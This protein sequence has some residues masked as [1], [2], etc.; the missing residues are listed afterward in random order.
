MKWKVYENTTGTRLQYQ[1]FVLHDGPPLADA[2]TPTNYMIETYLHSGRFT[3]RL[4]G[5]DSTGTSS[6]IQIGPTLAARTWHEIELIVNADAK[7][8]NVFIN[9]TQYGTNLP[10]TRS[11]QGKKIDH[12]IIGTRQSGDDN[13]IYYDDIIITP[14]SNLTLNPITDQVVEIG[15]EYTAEVPIVF[16][17][18]GAELSVVSSNS[19]A[20]SAR[21]VGSEGSRKVSLTGIAAA[22]NVRITVTVK[23]DLGNEEETSFH[24]ALIVPKMPDLPALD[25]IEQL[26]VNAVQNVKVSYTPTNATVITV[27][28]SNPEVAAVTVQSQTNGSA[29][30]QVRG[31]TAG[32]ATIT[33]TATRPGGLTVEDRFEVTVASRTAPIGLLDINFNALATGVFDIAGPAAGTPNTALPELTNV[34]NSAST[35]ATIVDA[36]NG[37]KHFTLYSPSADTKALFR[38]SP[39]SDGILVFEFRW[40][41]DAALNDASVSIVGGSGAGSAA[42]D[43]AFTII[44]SE[45]NRINYRTGGTANTNNTVISDWTAGRW[46]GVKVEMNVKAKTY[47][48]SIDGKPVAADV[49]FRYPVNTQNGEIWGVAVGKGNNRDATVRI[50]DLKVYVPVS[51]ALELN[52]N[53]LEATNTFDISSLPN[54]LLPALT[55]MLNPTGANLRVLEKT[56]NTA[57]KYIGITGTSGNDTKAILTFPAINSGKARIAFKALFDKTT[58]N[59]SGSISIIGGEGDGSATNNYAFMLMKNAATQV[60]HRSGDAPTANTKILSGIDPSQNDIWINVEVELD[61]DKKLYRLW[62]NGVKLT[63]GATAEGEYFRFRYNPDSIWGIMLGKGSNG[64]SLTSIDD[65]KVTILP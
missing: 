11:T 9:G 45:G 21:I 49:P 15:E 56:S 31:V 41:P 40:Q 12:V 2:T 25:D 19:A 27:T 54:T 7:T 44:K 32:K 16:T 24:V 4:I 13:D 17:P 61:V 10:F 48:L 39:V 47:D 37:D 35:T 46:I 42:A 60:V 38:F 64:T 8:Y 55:S 59:V 23:D 28:S 51:S 58:S 22:E 65:I 43:C 33:V 14:L 34:F 3:Y 36:G 30:I 26:W 6:Q 50:D 1:R 29:S 18:Y 53:N 52:F 5:G 63:A 62:V 20:V 57:D